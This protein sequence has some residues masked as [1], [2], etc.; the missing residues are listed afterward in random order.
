MNPRTKKLACDVLTFGET[1][2]LFAPGSVREKLEF[3]SSFQASIGGAESNCAI[4]LGRLGHSVCW[5][6]RLG[7]DPFGYRV[8]KTLRGEN[9]NVDR[10]EMSDRESTGIMFKEPA[11]GNSSR[12]FYYR[13]NSAAAALRIESFEDLSAEYLF[14][15]G[16]TPA[17]SESNRKLTFEVVDRFREMGTKVVFDPNMRFK[18]WDADA[19]RIVFLEL[20]RRCDILVPSL[21]E[22]QILT[23]EKDQ[24]AMLEGL[25]KIGPSQ[26]VLKAGELGAWFANGD[27]RGYCPGFPVTEI[28]PVGAGDGFCAGLLSALLDGRSLSDAVTRGAA[29]GAMCVSTFGD[30]HGLPDRTTLE[31]FIAGTQTHGR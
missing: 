8:L 9:V 10:V 24:I 22:A 28:D 21:I 16:I 20:A 13:R 6:S 1:M 23:G 4:G 29:L 2:V 30:Y 17:L 5:I 3:T 31:T 26:V 25:Q 19:A 7:N 11:S 12:I 18:L 14:V 15:T 27:Q